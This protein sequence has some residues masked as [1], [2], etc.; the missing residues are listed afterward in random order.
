M[1]T[2]VACIA[3]FSDGKNQK[4]ID[5]IVSAIQAVSRVEVLQFSM[6][7]DHHR[8][9]ITFAGEKD[10]IGEAAVKATEKAA[11]LINLTEHYGVHPRIGATDVIPFVPIQNATIDDCVEIAHEV[12]KQIYQRLSIPVYFYEAAAKRPNRQR[13]ENI[14]R[15]QFEELEVRVK[16]DSNYL[17]DFGR[18]YLHPT[19]GATVVGARTF[20]IAYNIVLNSSDILIAKQI[21]TS[22]RSSSGGLPC[23]KAIG[24]NLKT[25]AKVQVSM[26]LTNFKVTSMQQVFDQVLNK[27]TTLKVTIAYSEIIGLV[28]RKA[29]PSNPAS[30][31]K[32][33]DF[34]QNLIFENYLGE[35]L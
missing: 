35:I 19:A 15:G 33:K 5:Q 30:S 23:V 9:V 26:N 34:A 17:P 31:L 21:A 25:K 8:T 24:V 6:D 32:L 12:G 28:P 7:K 10:T 2:I 1:K 22:I 18:N 13:L 11:E 14:R 20:L 4:V 27:A 16:T 3:N 29:L